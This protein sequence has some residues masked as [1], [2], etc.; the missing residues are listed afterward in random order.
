MSETL[1][2][3]RPYARAAFEAAQD[4]KALGAWSS[5]LKFTAQMLND[6]RVRSMVMDPRVSASDLAALLL[7]SGEAVDG[8]F[9]RFIALL[10]ENQRADLL[11]EIAQL[12]DE[13]KR[14]AER[15]LKVTVRSATPLPAGEEDTIRAA[16]KKRFNRDIEMDQQ[17]DPSLIGGAIIDTGDVVID[18]SVRGRLARLET[19]LMH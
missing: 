6:A 2:L 17:V 10:I 7:P 16:L 15:V 1:T 13:L 12:F 8:D 3:A 19:A 4:A 18:G 5:N 9:G 11:V 14:E